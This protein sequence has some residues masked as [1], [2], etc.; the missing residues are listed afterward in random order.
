MI[1]NPIL[2]GFNPDPSILR[3]G[4]DYYIATST[5]EWYPGIALYHSKDLK[6]WTQINYALTRPEQ[7][8]LTGLDTARGVWAPC[9]SYSEKY[10]KYYLTFSV[11][12]NIQ[13]QHFDLDNFMVE[14]DSIHGPWSDAVYINSAGFDPSLFHDDDG[15][16]WIVNLVW[17]NRE[18]Y[19]HPGYIALQQWDPTSKKLIDKP[20]LISRGG[21]NRGCLEAPH[22]YKRNGYYYLMTAEGGTG[23][24]HAVVI[25]RSKNIEGP[26]ESDPHG[27][28]ITSQ[29]QDFNE[30][31]IDDA[32][33]FHQ[34]NPESILQKSGHGSL[35][36]T[37]TG[38]LYIAHLCARPFVPE[39]RCMLGRETA[40]QKVYETQD[41]WIRLKGSGNLAQ[42]EV[43]EPDFVSVS[44]KS[45]VENNIFSFT[46]FT[47]TILP[48]EFQTYRE[49]GRAWVSFDEKRGLGLRGQGS[50][51]SPRDK[52]LIARRVQSFHCSATTLVDFDP[53]N[54][55]Q[56][57]GLTAYYSALNFYYLRI[58]YSETLGGKALAVMQSDLGNKQEIKSSRIRLPDN[59]PV[60]LKAEINQ[61]DLSFFYSFDN[62]NWQRVGDALDATLLSDEYG[63][64]KFTGS[65]FGLFCQ[66]LHT[67]Q[68]QAYFKFFDYQEYE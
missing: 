42:L 10:R 36:E 5:F 61:R 27:V 52:S 19:E 25:S 17:E 45:A 22:L 64:Q 3:V 67:K 58:Y 37:Q 8:N 55:H 47:S 57:A 9:L 7:I 68:K 41:G 32:Y 24:G 13:G 63:G 11:V 35:V 30:R 43:E 60:Y 4:D 26:Y 6:N 18:G 23:Y 53:E 1:K 56:S 65:F 40:I 33:K 29:P 49:P 59:T 31:G 28:V 16:Q 48:Y 50:L 14:S 51:F 66:D 54:T 21:T 2:K 34:Y 44:A 38:E 62:Q 20:Q 15:K 12:Y 46:E 39:L